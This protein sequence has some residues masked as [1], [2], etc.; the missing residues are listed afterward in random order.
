MNI[1]RVL[2]TT[3]L[4][5]T[6]AATPAAA[7]ASLALSEP[8]N[9]TTIMPNSTETVSLELSEQAPATS[10]LD[11]SLFGIITLGVIGLFWIRRHTSEL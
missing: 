10:A 4:L 2:A 5:L 11:L 3:V 6:L 1:V 8:D 7:A 9:T